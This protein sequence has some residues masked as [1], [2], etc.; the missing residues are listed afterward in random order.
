MPLG[1]RERP[2]Q[3]EFDRRQIEPM[4]VEGDLH[5]RVVDLEPFPCRRSRPA[6]APQ[7]RA[8]TR[9]HF[10][11]TEWF[12]DV[13]VG[14]E[15][16]PEQPVDLV[17]ARGDHDDRHVGERAHLAAHG[18]AIH[19]G[20]HHVEEHQ[21]GIRCPRLEHRA[22]AVAHDARGEASVQQIIGE[23]ARELRLVLHDED[24]R[25]GRV[26]HAGRPTGDITSMRNPPSVDDDARIV[27]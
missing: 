7:H 20:Q 19:A 24:Q 13:V 8:D 22:R 16:E 23:N 6:R 25:R 3:T 15:L 26:V 11:R 10:A 1:V 4:S 14:A 17:D 18:H 5:P 9:D 21:R 12:A 27:P 2:Q